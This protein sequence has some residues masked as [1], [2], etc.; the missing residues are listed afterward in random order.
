MSESTFGSEIS[1]NKIKDSSI[2]L[3]RVERTCFADELDELLNSL[4]I[5]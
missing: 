5:S 4:L 1:F 2:S 3:G